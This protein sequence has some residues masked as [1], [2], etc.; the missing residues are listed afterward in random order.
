MKIIKIIVVL[1]C[2]AIVLSAFGILFKRARNSSEEEVTD[3]SEVV[4][5]TPQALTI[6]GVY[7]FD[8]S[9]KISDDIDASVGEISENISFVYDSVTYDYFEYLPQ[10]LG[11]YINYGSEAESAAYPYEYGWQTD[12]PY[13][14]FGSEPQE[15]SAELFAFLQQVAVKLEIAYFRNRPFYFENGMTWI[16]WFDSEYYW[17]S[18]FWDYDAGEE[19]GEADVLWFGSDP[20]DGSYLYVIEN[21]VLC[22][23]IVDGD[24]YYIK[25]YD[26]ILPGGTYKYPGI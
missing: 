3:S 12:T 25:V 5:T 18:N 23:R 13:I 2:A 6:S 8:T 21:N 4:E 26:D 11:F 9:K 15:V 19:G 7:R 1:L 16:E 20:E 14:D 10:N 24:G 22:G 17:E